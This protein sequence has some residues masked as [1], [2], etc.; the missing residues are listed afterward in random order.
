MKSKFFNGPFN[1][2][3][4][5]LLP[6][7]FLPPKKI[8]KNESTESTKIKPWRIYIPKSNKLF[9]LESSTTFARKDKKN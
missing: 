4:D 8:I 9:K 3:P 2:K 7:H 6:I 1:I 5:I